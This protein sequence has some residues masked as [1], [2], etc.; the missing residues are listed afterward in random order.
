M[1][2]VIGAQPIQICRRRWATR[3]IVFRMP[4]MLGSALALLLILLVV[5]DVHNRSP[6]LGASVL[7]LG[8]LA[9]TVLNYLFSRDVLFPSCMFSAVWCLTSAVYVFFPSDIDPLGWKTVGTLLGGNLCFT[10]GC[11]LGDRP[12]SRRDPWWNSPCRNPQPRRILLL[13]SMVMVPVVAFNA[14]KLAGVYNLSPAFFIAA[15]LAVVADQ[16]AGV[17]IYHNPFVSTAP[18]VAVSTAFILIMEETDRRRIRIGIAAAIILGLLTT[19]RVIWLLLFCGWFMLAMMRRSDRSVRIIGKKF[20]I[21]GLLVVAALTLAPLLTKSE[22]QSDGASDKSGLVTAAN[23]AAAYIAGPVAGFNYIVYHPG[24]FSD[25]SNNTFSEI[26]TPASRLGFRY[27]PPPPFDPFVWIPFPINVFTAYKLYYV[28]FGVGGCLVAFLTFGFISGYL[29]RAVIR[30]NRLAA[31]CFAYMYFA[32]MF[33]PFQDSYHLFTRYA[34]MLSY[35]CLYFILS[36]RM[37]EIRLLRFLSQ[38][39]G[40]RLA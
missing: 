23:L 8:F 22:T 4:A 38:E 16:A 31:F 3:T 15:R 26:L 33:T 21:A 18:T 20:V 19:G 37:P 11:F 40:G 17:S 13:Y 27:V 24:A 29:F 35:G 1:N 5:L 9:S 6:A 12:L 28:D 10:A 36:R 32:L 2:E 39:S 14:M 34:Y 7:L 25:Q 30:G